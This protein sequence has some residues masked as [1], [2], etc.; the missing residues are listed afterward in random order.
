MDTFSLLQF[1]HTII[2]E[3]PIAFGKDSCVHVLKT[4]VG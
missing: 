2:V 3:F 4:L 1:A